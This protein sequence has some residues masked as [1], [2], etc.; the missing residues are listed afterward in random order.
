MNPEFDLHAHVDHKAQT[1]TGPCQTC[2][3]WRRAIGYEL[4]EWR[5]RRQ[6]LIKWPSANIAAQVRDTRAKASE[7]EANYQQHLDDAH[8][9]VEPV[10]PRRDKPLDVQRRR[11]PNMPR[12]RPGQERCPTCHNGCTPKPDGF[13]RKHNAPDGYPCGNRTRETRTA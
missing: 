7:S 11:N 6:T 2:L 13:L 10:A 3:R 1:A 9:G 8:D 5:N 12:L 4:A